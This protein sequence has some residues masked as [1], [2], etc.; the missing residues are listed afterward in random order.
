MTLTH[1]T[2]T[3]RRDFSIPVGEVFRAWRETGDLEAWAYP[4]D[5]RWSSRI[6]HHDFTIGGLKQALFGPKGDAPYREESRYLDIRYNRHIINSER[7]LSGDGRLIS[8]SLVSIEFVETSD[9]CELL[10]S[11]QITLLDEADTSEQRR[12]GWNE[13]LERLELF[14]LR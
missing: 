5:D 12:A 2:I 10:V 9:G 3:I 4:G 6:E 7:I 8:T 14:L 13:V 1:D 11:D